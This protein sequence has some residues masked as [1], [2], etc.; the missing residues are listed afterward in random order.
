MLVI[1]LSLSS[2]SWGGVLHAHHRIWVLGSQLKVLFLLKKAHYQLCSQPWPYRTNNLI[3]HSLEDQTQ[4][5]AEDKC[6][7]VWRLYLLRWMHFSNYK[8][9]CEKGWALILNKCEVTGILSLSEK[10]SGVFGA[11]LSA[12]TL[13]QSQIAMYRKWW[14]ARLE[15]FS[16]SL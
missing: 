16:S 13:L 10:G 7:L 3:Q 1:C 14:K 15:R 11:E 12:Q 9:K 5:P 2:K 8:N 6:S 4:A